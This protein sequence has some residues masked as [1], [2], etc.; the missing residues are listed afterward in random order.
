MKVTNL[1]NDFK[2]LLGQMNISP[3][4]SQSRAET[5]LVLL[6][7]AVWWVDGRDGDTAVGNLPH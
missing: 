2:M 3:S 5:G 1:V 6:F 7:E 4:L